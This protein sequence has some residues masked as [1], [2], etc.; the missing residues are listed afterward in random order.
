MRLN[1]RVEK[2][3]RDA[4]A[5]IV[6]GAKLSTAGEHLGADRLLALLELAHRLAHDAQPRDRV[7][8]VDGQRTRA[9]RDAVAE[10]AALVLA[11]DRHGDERAQLEALGA[12]AA[13]SCSHSRSAPL[14]TVSTTSLTVP[15]SASLIE[16]EV[17]QV[18]ADDAE[19][20]VRADLD[21]QRRRRAPG[22]GRPRRSRRR[23]R[24]PSR[25]SRSAAPGRVQHHD[26][27]RG[28]LQPGAHRAERA[29]GDELRRGRL[30]LRPARP[31]RGAAA[32]PGPGRGRTGPSR[33]RRRRRRR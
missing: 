7:V 8:D 16:L 14:T 31:R 9:S 19:A 30:G 24:P 2:F 3:S 1:R 29:G 5:S 32:R 25:T 17:A 18:V 12:H 21:V 15:P 26:R 28:G 10:L 4:C 27:A 23:P 11:A 6:G 33:G 13:S 22:S 20:A